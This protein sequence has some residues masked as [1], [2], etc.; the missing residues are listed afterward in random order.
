MDDDATAPPIDTL[1]GAYNTPTSNKIWSDVKKN[2]TIFSLIIFFELYQSTGHK[3][4]IHHSKLSQMVCSVFSAS[5]F[6]FPR[7]VNT[8]DVCVCVCVHII[9]SSLCLSSPSRIEGSAIMSFWSIIPH[10]CFL[11][12]SFTQRCSSSF[13][14]PLPP[15]SF[16]DQ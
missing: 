7:Y 5:D 1:R 13:L 12:G 16:V 11:F 6:M 2:L 8:H 14:L 3:L 15:P 10:V 9:P 4:L